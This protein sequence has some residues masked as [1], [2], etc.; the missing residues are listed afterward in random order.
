MTHRFAMKHDASQVT[1]G[2]S[3]EAGGGLP[4]S[5]WRDPHMRRPKSYCSVQ[6]NGTASNGVEPLSSPSP[7]HVPNAASTAFATAT[8]CSTV[9]P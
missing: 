3:G 6:K 1:G 7:Y 4:S 2:E 8:T 9:N 5:G